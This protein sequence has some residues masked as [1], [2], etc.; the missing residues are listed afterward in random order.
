MVYKSVISDVGIKLVQPGNG[1]LPEIK[2]PNTVIN[3]WE[4]LTFDFTAQIGDPA[5]P[6]VYDQIVIF[7]DFNARTAET[8]GYFDNIILSE[9]ATLDEPQVAAPDPTVPEAD[10]IS[11]FSG[12][13]TDITV[14][15]WLTPWSVGILTDLDI[16]GNATKKYSALDYVG[17]EANGDNSIDASDMN[18]INMHVWTPNS[19]TYRVKLVDY[20]TDNANGGGDDVEHEIV[21]ENPTQNEWV[22]KNIALADFTNLTTKSNISQIILSSLPAGQSVL[23]VDNVYFSKTMVNSVSVPS[24]NK[25]SI[26]PNPA[27]STLNLDIDAAT[28]TISNYSLVNIQGQVVLSNDVNSTSIN[29]SIDVYALSLIHI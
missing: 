14:D 2:V 11:L 13:Y 6:T 15:T 10:V 24:F 27:T 9:G 8:I 1:A 18:Y 3:E 22:E 16:A 28:A 4:E 25:F 26:Y 7:M 12:V 5:N 23:Y 19:T 29:T 21:I 17:I 20:G